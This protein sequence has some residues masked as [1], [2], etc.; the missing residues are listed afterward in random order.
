MRN[1]AKT[2]AFDRYSNEYDE[3]FLRNRALY[4][5]ELEAIRGLLPAAGGR[6]LEIGVGSGKFAVP[7]GI[8][9]GVEPSEAMA[10]K[11][12]ALGVEVHSGVAEALPFGDAE[13]DLALMVTTIC[14]VDDVHASLREALRVL[15][16]GGC[17]VVGF[18]DGESQLG[19][20][21]QA[22]KE[23]SRFYREA[24]FLSATEVVESLQ[25]A[26]F[27][28]LDI[29]QTLIP[30]KEQNASTEGFGEGAFVVIRAMKA[31]GLAQE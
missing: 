27:G 25:R 5:A 30:G 12:R 26:G 9:V 24:V 8:T 16:P 2:E 4:E 28:S 11:A 6:W 21:Y 13:F 15:T 22:R 14:F 31:K 18:V 23:R 29:R 19:R 10:S 1:H 3:W 20:E 17:L 7:L